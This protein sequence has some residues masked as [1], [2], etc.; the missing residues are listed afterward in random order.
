MKKLV[1]ISILL[2]LLAAA[3]FA[4]I[5]DADGNR[6]PGFSVGLEAR[7]SPEV[8]KITTPTGDNAN[9]DVG[10]I[11]GAR[12]G[13]LAYDGNGTFDF[14][15]SAHKWTTPDL[16]LKFSYSDP[17]GNFGGLA[18]IDAADWILSLSAQDYDNYDMD[19]QNVLG[20][21]SNPF[22]DWNLWGKAGIIKLYVGNEANRG[23]TD[24]YAG[25]FNGMALL[26]LR[27]NWARDNYGIITPGTAGLAA[28]DV[29]DLGSSLDINN[30]RR[31]VFGTIDGKQR[32]NAYFALT[33]DLSPIK[34]DIAGDFGRDFGAITS[35]QDTYSQGGGAFRVS[36]KGIVDIIDFDVIYKLFGGDPTTDIKLDDPDPTQPDGKGLWNH[37]FG[38]FA[39]IN[40]IDGLGIGVGYSGYT[41]ARENKK[42]V[43][44]GDEITR[45][46]YPYINGIDLRF[47]FNGV[48]NL[49]LTFNNNFS[50]G[51][52]VNDSDS[53]TE[54][55]GLDGGLLAG[56]NNNAA[57]RAQEFSQG[58]FAMYNAL[59]VS[60]GITDELT[61]NV[62]IGNL[63]NTFNETDKMDESKT[64]I[65]D[66]T[67][68]RFHGSVSAAYSFTDNV[69]IEAGLEFEA[70]S[71]NWQKTDATT[72]NWGTFTFGI[73]VVF[74][75]K[76]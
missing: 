19:S 33:A 15:S 65:K 30:L 44:T 64:V 13:G 53:R 51:A 8:L 56:A 2:T 46:V 68:D 52:I 3:A 74:T 70:T 71:A 43:P 49:V 27:D 60:Y 69:T 66:T 31:H 67:A 37:S 10:T 72:Q 4:D 6:K 36:G 11:D 42:D 41:A 7:F 21:L 48:E 16:A 63:L 17:N 76:F 59:G 28:G 38:I 5:D 9:V 40:I 57:S 1:A 73:P 18:A 22:G 61:A 24:R 23:V 47:Q 32:G 20:F 35:G 34:V 45:Y 26:S 29:L 55:Y 62:S 39:N 14:L 54:V 50:F 12:V 58:Y 75:V 25:N